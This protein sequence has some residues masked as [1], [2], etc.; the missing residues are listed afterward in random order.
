MARG[1][2]KSAGKSG[3]RAR[4]PALHARVSWTST[5]AYGERRTW[6]GTVG[7]CLAA[8]FTV[9]TEGGGVEYVFYT[10]DWRYIE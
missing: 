8:Q 10:D 2:S 1:V 5:N 3:S 6:V 7:D 4:R 9:Y